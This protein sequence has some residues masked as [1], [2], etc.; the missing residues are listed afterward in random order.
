MTSVPT[1]GALV[2]GH[3]LVRLG[4][5]AVLLGVT[6]LLVYEGYSLA[7][8]GD[9]T[10]EARLGVLAFLGANLGL[11]LLATGV[12]AVLAARARRGPRGP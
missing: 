1:L 4:A 6:P 10:H 7:T 2:R 12:V 9:R 11:L 5:R 8:G 3:W